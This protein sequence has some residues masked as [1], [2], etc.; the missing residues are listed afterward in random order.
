MFGAGKSSCVIWQVRCLASSSF[1]SC[2]T[3]C[4]AP[5]NFTLLASWLPAHLG[6]FQLLEPKCSNTAIPVP[7]AGLACFCSHARSTS[8]WRLAER[9]WLVVRCLGLSHWLKRSR[10]FAC[11]FAL[12]L[13]AIYWQCCCGGLSR[14]QT[15]LRQHDLSGAGGVRDNWAGPARANLEQ[16]EPTPKTAA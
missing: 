1:T 13:E 16:H 12:Q 4:A 2:A 8:P 10:G 3:R 5:L 11:L 14:L 15:S 9:M 7:P 6:Q